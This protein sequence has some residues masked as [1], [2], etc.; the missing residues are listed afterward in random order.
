MLILDRDSIPSNVHFSDA[1]VAYILLYLKKNGHTSRKDLLTYLGMGEGSFRS[2][3]KV[4]SDADIVRTSRKGVVL[5]SN[6]RRLAM[7]MNIRPLDLD[8]G[9]SLGIYRQVI[10]V[11]HAADRI[12]TGMEQVKLSTM[13]GGVGCTTW[14]MVDNNLLMPPHLS[15]MPDAYNF[16]RQIVAAAGLKDGDVL[17]VCGADTLRTARLAAMTVAL[18]LI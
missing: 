2:L 5:G 14:V 13:V 9:Y 4:L 1:D 11:S 16:S 8:V 6:G 10:V 12:G 15:A 7:F 18:D 3:M 17:L